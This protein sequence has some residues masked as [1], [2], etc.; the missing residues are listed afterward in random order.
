MPVAHPVVPFRFG[1]LSEAPTPPLGE[2]S[3]V[4]LASVL[5]F[6]FFLPRQL[7]YNLFLY[8]VLL[9][10]PLCRCFG[11]RLSFQSQDPLILSQ[12]TII[13]T[14]FNFDTNYMTG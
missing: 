5:S 7:Q 11:A 6:L 8:I 10:S 4:F 14:S 1:L 3:L 12:W 2:S 13:L 9:S